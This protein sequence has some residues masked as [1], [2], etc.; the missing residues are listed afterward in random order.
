MK[1]LIKFIVMT[2]IVFG[3]VKFA[4]YIFLPIIISILGA[5][6]LAE[7]CGFLNCLFNSDIYSL[8][9][10]YVFSVL[11]TIVMGCLSY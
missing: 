4:A 6:E 10:V 7:V 3:L 2:L 9:A 8:V 11:L 5:F 1:S